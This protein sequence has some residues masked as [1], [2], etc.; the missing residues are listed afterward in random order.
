MGCQGTSEVSVDFTC[1]SQKAFPA[2][3]ACLVVSGGSKSK[4]CYKI[5]HMYKSAVAAS[6][7]FIMRDIKYLK[8]KEHEIGTWSPCDASCLNFLWV[9]VM[10]IYLATNQ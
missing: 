3:Y 5:Q 2:F 10:N 8:W 1:N 4:T 6:V 9:D 7:G